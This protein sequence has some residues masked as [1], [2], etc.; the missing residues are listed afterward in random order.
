ME[1]G[2]RDTET[3]HRKLFYFKNIDFSVYLVVSCHVLF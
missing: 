2:V 1:I 3:M